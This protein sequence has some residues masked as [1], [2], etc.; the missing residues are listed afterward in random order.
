MP[1]AGTQR[2]TGRPPTSLWNKISQ[3][4]F[5]TSVGFDSIERAIVTAIKCL[6]G[7]P[8]ECTQAIINSLSEEA[9]T[10]LGTYLEDVTE[11]TIEHIL[12]YFRQE[13]QLEILLERI[14]ELQDLT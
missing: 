13:D 12:D 1:D 8:G 6:T 14:E 2:R 5:D 3:I 11:V 10:R 4:P 7:G 9:T